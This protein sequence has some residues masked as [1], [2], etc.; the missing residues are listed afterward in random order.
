MCLRLGGFPHGVARGHDMV[1]PHQA[2][3]IVVLVSGCPGPWERS[4][5]EAVEVAAVRSQTAVAAMGRS[6]PVIACEMLRVADAT[7][8]GCWMGSSAVEYWVEENAED[9][10]EA[11]AK[12]RVR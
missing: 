1:K 5:V 10:V 2:V 4:A 7:R 11:G 12:P 3:I 6:C 9:V 8:K